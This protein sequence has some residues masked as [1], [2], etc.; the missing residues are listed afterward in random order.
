MR[1]R[2]ETG[3]GELARRI[4]AH[5]LAAALRLA[6]REV[7]EGAWK[8]LS[9]VLGLVFSPLGYEMRDDA[10]WIIYDRTEHSTW[11]TLLPDR[12]SQSDPPGTVP[13]LPDQ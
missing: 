2:A 10:L 13:L 7:G 8:H 5:P 12:A 9:G 6:R 3:L 4:E 11:F 1:Q